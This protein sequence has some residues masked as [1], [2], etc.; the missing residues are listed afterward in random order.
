MSKENLF[1]LIALTLIPGIGPVNAKS[2]IGYC[3][4]ADRIFKTKK[5]SLLK[6]PGIGENTAEAIVHHDVFERAESEMKF[7]ETKKIQALSYLDEHYPYRLKACLDAPIVV[8]YSGNRD[9]NAEKVL[10]VV[11][12][13]NATDYGKQIV[14]E[15]IES[16][17]E[18]NV[19]VVSGLA[20]GIDIA[21][22]KACLKKNLPTVGVVGHGL[23]RIYPYAH[24]EVARKMILNGGILTEFTSETLPDRQNFPR[25]N[26]IVAGMIDALVV[27]E[28]AI[29]GG[30]LITAM[31]ADGYNKDVL[32]YPGNVNHKYSQGCH[33][34]IKTNR[35]ALVE[36]GNDILEF[37]NWGKKET[38]PKPQREL[39]IELK[40]AEK[41]IYN[42]L[43][44]SEKGI[45]ELTMAVQLQPSVLAGSL[46]NLEFQGLIIALPGKRYKLV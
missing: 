29:D 42:A 21:A 1:Y 20:Y 36:N 15:L 19:L 11:G 12:T 41:L 44:E 5:H 32:A 35:A 7:I 39:F 31:L 34:L 9:L 26:R 18:E 30:A 45:D 43:Q 17:K 27:V 37:L 40:D 46:L 22:H 13:R 38:T 25:R 28:T 8:Y 3:G 14:E 23:D 24:R 4:S 16:I 6:I 10:G 33:H 2:L